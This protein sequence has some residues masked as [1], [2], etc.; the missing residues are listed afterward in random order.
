MLANSL[1]ARRY[2]GQELQVS[3]HALIAAATL[4][5]S[6]ILVLAPDNSV[7]LAATGGM[8]DLNFVISRAANYAL[9]DLGNF[10]LS[11]TVIVWSIVVT[12]V[13]L[14][15]PEFMRLTHPRGAL[16]A[17]GVAIVCLVFCY[18][19]YFTHQFTTGLRLVGR[20]QNEAL[21]LVSFI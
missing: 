3:H 8:P 7:R 12:A 10:L 1:L 2:L 17:V 21:I 11:P 4:I 6:A 16:L 20:A 19:D 5:G 15:E 14:A 9:L 13:T 18:F